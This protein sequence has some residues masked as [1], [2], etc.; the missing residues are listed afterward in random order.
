MTLE[1]KREPE[2][3]PPYS[4]TGDL[5][6]F[7]RCGLQYRYQNGSQLPPSRPVQLWFGDFIHGVME[8]AYRIWKA[9]PPPFPWPCNPT[10][11]PNPP[12]T[13]RAFHDIGVIG[14]VVEGT[15]RAQGKNPRSKDLRSSAYKRAE[16]AV[17]E[18]GPHLFPLVDT[19]EEKIIGTRA[20]PPAP[21]GV[22]P[23]AQRYE[24]HGVIDVVSDVHLNTATTGNVIRDAIVA[25]CPKLSG[26]YEVIIDYKGSR[27]PLVAHSYWAQGDWQ[28]QTYAW[29]R[30]RQ[31]SS[32][33]VVAG[34]LV[35]INELSPGQDDVK[36]M[37]KGWKQGTTD[38]VPEKGSLDYYLLSTWT[39]GSAV[40]DF[41]MDFRM[42]RALRVIAIDAAS[43]TI[44]TG[45]FDEVVLEIERL[46]NQEA[47]VGQI[48]TVWPACG[49]DETCSA[50]DFRHFCTSP[51]PRQG[52]HP[53]TAPMAP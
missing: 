49:D 3:I 9:A 36:E 15:L 25:A 12:D 45:K 28:V 40:P 44:A 24:L 18:L 46:A 19:A 38:V 42:R 13:G 26:H 11:P 8:S 39:P 52:V 5:L 6:S 20:V 30:T 29:L 35:Y 34:V 10:I 48:M 47:N 33:P 7:L 2:I 4:L 37:Q 50:C 22:I 23:R 32:L 41:S 51:S 53:I 27:R 21:P 16:K 1:R 31:A 17:N 14:D 43:Q